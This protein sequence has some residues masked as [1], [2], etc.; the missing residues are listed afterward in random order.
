M[1]FPPRKWKNS[2]FPQLPTFI[3]F[4][5]GK[6]LL[7][8][9]SKKCFFRFRL[10]NA[11][12]R[13]S[14]LYLDGKL[15]YK[16]VYPPPGKHLFFKLFKLR[17]F[18]WIFFKKFVESLTCFLDFTTFDHVIHDD[19]VLLRVYFCDISNHDSAR[20]HSRADA[21]AL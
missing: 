18:P 2:V 4:F 17:F 5:W 13:L 6:I 14:I 8:Y 11:P 7:Y 21:R 9:K 15:D 16:T 10:S 12:T 19:L 1:T 3:D 20:A